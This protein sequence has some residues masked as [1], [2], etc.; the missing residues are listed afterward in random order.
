MTVELWMDLDPERLERDRREISIFAPE[1][2][3]VEPIRSEASVTHGGWQGELP[4]WPFDRPVPTGLSDLL[5]GSPLVVEVH[6]SAAHPMVAPRIYP[7]DPLPEPYEHSQHVW[8]VAPGGSLCLLQSDTAWLPE[9]SITELIAKAA[10]WRIEYALMKTGAISEMT[11]NGIVSDASLDE[12]IE[13]T[14]QRLGATEDG[15]AE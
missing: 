3:F 1:L 5:G 15:G 12:V 11:T 10:A 14:A 2:S 7:V 9:A 8:H 4:L 13:V 6:Y